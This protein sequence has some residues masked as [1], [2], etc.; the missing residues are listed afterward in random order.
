MDTKEDIAPLVA[1]VGETASGK[2]ELA[3]KIAEKFGGE[4][5]SADSRTLY[6]GMDIGTAKPTKTDRLR[7]PHYLI[8]IRDPNKPL[9]VAEFKLLADQAIKEIIKRGKLPILVGGS[10]L[11]VDSVLFNFSF[12]KIAH[13]DYRKQLNDLT[14][15][16]IQD[17]LI[18]RG[19]ELPNNH[20]N[21]RHL[22]RQL[23]TNGQKIP[24]G[25]VRP[26]TLII[27]LRRSK[28]DLDT[29]V[30]KRVKKMMK[31]GLDEEAKRLAKRYGWDIEPMRTIG[32]REFSPEESEGLERDEIIQQII[33]DTINYSKRQRTWFK[34]NKHIQWVDKQ[35]EAVELVTTFLSK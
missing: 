6:K 20:E 25:K 2:S 16:Q 7:V 23:E 8:D 26:N 10:G 1:I 3:L 4:I 5:I 35:I 18:A 22:I 13:P 34:R 11:Y 28:E 31:A 24:Q 32:Y 19:I 15:N 27:G 12:K 33:R 30:T 17:E 29:A 14:V 9:K 21:K